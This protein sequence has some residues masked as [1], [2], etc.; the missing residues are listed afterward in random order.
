MT[1]LKS[2]SPA[3]SSSNPV[4]DRRS[5]LGH[6]SGA[7]LWLGVPSLIVGCGGGGGG[8]AGVG[9]GN[10]VPEG[11][12][13]PGAGGELTPEKR[14]ASLR[15]V[16]AAC[17]G[18]ESRRLAPAAYL[19]ELSAF[20]AKDPNYAET[21]V[22]ERSLTV[23][24]TFV[25]GRLHMVSH[26]FK[27]GVSAS[28]AAM[29]QRQKTGAALAAKEETALPASRNARLLH[30][31]FTP[32]D[33]QPAIVEMSRWLDKR[34]YALQP[35]QE[36]DAHITTLRQLKGDGFFYINTHGGVK[37]TRY[38]DPRSPMRFSIQSSTLIDLALEAQPD[39]K[40]DFADLRLTYFTAYNG[41]ATVDGNGEE[42]GLKDTRYGITAEFVDAYWQFAN[43]S[44]VVI[45]ACNSANS[46]DN[47]WVVDF[48]D[49]CHRKNAGLYL[50]WTEICSPPAAF[51]IPKYC[52]DRMLGANAFKPETPNQRAFPGEDVIADM[53][54][55][56][57]NHDT[58]T[59]IGAY[60]IAKPNPASLV[61]HILSPS[62]HHLETDEMTER[63]HLVGVF[64]SVQG[65]VEV[66][67]VPVHV[68]SWS[69]DRVVCEL[70]PVS[71][72]GAHGRVV[73]RVGPLESNAR[74]LTLWTLHI[75][76]HEPS[77]LSGSLKIDGTATLHLRADIGQ[78]REAPGEAP[79][80]PA[81]HTVATR[82]SV[83]PLAASGSFDGITWSGALTYT[84]IPAPGARVLACGFKLDAL[85]P[86]ASLRT[87]ALGI[88]LGHAAGDGFTAS[89][90]APMPSVR[91]AAAMSTMDGMEMFPQDNAGGTVDIPLFAF[92]INFD[93]DCTIPRR[94]FKDPANGVTFSW[95]SATP[96]HPPLADDAV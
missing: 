94:I 51:D 59:E 95:D 4:T 43:D 41:L 47:K 60:F 29:A 82:E 5:F 96:L 23:W 38:Q 50:G 74:W 32:F 10:W 92:R 39:F 12:S 11:G 18:L 15:A 85:S 76:Y 75:R 61:S 77:P 67:K 56:G 25:D 70:K 2:R 8:G 88:G 13:G 1:L 20:M 58:G 79:T 72:G 84:A 65:E 69:H 37:Y 3:L 19:A 17:A 91:F 49:A 33:G 57:L 83:F 52:V 28:S 64:G 27:P 80:S 42:V 48:V 24:G 55:R 93:A 21:G 35:G 26:N 90:P 68:H 22:D 71:Q 73:A 53:Q 44:V 62:I 86:G 7:A 63:L 36:G 66:D 31:F 78:V 16:E 14:F 54:R 9:V 6:A 87:G 45:N 89:Y 34:G 30:S 46:A 81:R 40:A